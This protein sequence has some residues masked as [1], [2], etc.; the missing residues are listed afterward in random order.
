M[1]SVH[2]PEPE[3]SQQAA[4]QGVGEQVEELGRKVAAPVQ[5]AA[6]VREQR[7][8]V[9]QVPTAQALGEQEV[10]KPAKE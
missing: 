2:P 10:A 9:Q 7:K 1:V 3:A 8:P 4:A 5:L 6:T